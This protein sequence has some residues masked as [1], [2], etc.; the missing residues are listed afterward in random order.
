MTNQ[1]EFAI[2]PLEVADEEGLCDSYCAYFVF[3]CVF[4]LT[5]V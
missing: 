3:W 2:I 1:L 4:N 5:I